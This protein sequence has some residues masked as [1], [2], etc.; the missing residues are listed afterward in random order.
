MTKSI[1]L[2]AV[3]ILLAS[4]CGSGGGEA[5]YVGRWQ[6]AELIPETSDNICGI[7][8]LGVEGGH[9]ITKN[10]SE[11]YSLLTED[12]RVYTGEVAEDANGAPFLGFRNGTDSITYSSVTKD[13]ATIRIFREKTLSSLGGSFTCLKAWNG[14]AVRGE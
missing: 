5:D 1:L 11:T 10:E 4:G 2:C 8:L 7:D 13:S 14:Q 12:G 9:L 6:T 3:T